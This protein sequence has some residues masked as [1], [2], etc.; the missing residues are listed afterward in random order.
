M[1]SITIGG[2][3]RRLELADSQ[4]FEKKAAGLAPPAQPLRA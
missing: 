1:D 3:L 2:V 4:H